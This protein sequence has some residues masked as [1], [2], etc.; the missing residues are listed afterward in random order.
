M[1][2]RT[3]PPAPAPIRSFRFPR[4]ERQRLD[5]GIILYRAKCGDLPLVTVSAVVDAGAASELAG[6]EGLAWL[7]GNALEAG[8]ARR[9]GE[10]LAWE[11]ERLGA[12][13]ETFTTWD[14]LTVELTTRADRMPEALA[15][16]AEIVSEPAFPEHEVER[17][18][19][20]QL[21]EILRR[22]TEPRGLADDAAA[23][24]IFAEHATYARPLI[25]VEARVQSFDGAAAR[26][27]H[28]RRFTPGSTAVV[29]VGA[30]E[31]G[32]VA[33]EVARAFGDWQGAHEAAPA[34]T[35]EARAARTTVFLVD[36]PSAVQSELRI[37]H[38]GVPRHHEDYYALLVLNTIVAGAF[39][40]RL[41]ITLREKHG[42]TYGVR[43]NFAFRRAAG[44]FVIQTAVA[45]DVTARAVQETL[46]EL[47]AIQQDGVSEDEVRA[48]RDYLAGTFPLEMQTTEQI[49]ARI[50]HLH[51][52]QLGVDYFERYR[53][54]IGAVTRDDVVRVARD[55]LHLDRLSIVVVGNA[56]DIEEGLRSLGFGDIVHHDFGA[57]GAQGPAQP[58]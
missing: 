58:A 26:R 22:S 47:R 15:L 28:R 35:T 3:S 5:N 20:E 57:S 43:S 33:Q 23:R 44:P 14:A 55:H 54:Q 9:T 56:A 32:T 4:V 49:A 19:N 31:P 37:G 48:A 51:T 13:L 46:H 27:F 6:E 50:A 25:G 53:E 17:L 16:L 12:E 45:S 42:F 38:V 24:Y 41:N 11:L 30:V 39:T 29:V 52:Y 1:T 18:R 34:P 2:H 8:T 40:S 36:R 10:A 21:A 7:T